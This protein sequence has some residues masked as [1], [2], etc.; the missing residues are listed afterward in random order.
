M[1]MMLLLHVVSL[2]LSAVLPSQLSAAAVL[3]VAVG[4]CGI[5]ITASSQ[6]RPAH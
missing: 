5:G 2:P 1:P 4:L 6:A 3:L